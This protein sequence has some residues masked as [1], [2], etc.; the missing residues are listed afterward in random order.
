MGLV[1]DGFALSKAGY[2]ALSAALNL[3]HEL[4][5]EKECVCLNHVEW[6]VQS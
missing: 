2:L 1:H 4:Q 6:I 3:V 5:A